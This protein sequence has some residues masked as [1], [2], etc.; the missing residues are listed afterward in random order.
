M[1]LVCVYHFL[2]SAFLSPE[3]HS[4]SFKEVVKE[5]VFCGVPRYKSL[6]YI[7]Q[8][9]YNTEEGH[10][11]KIFSDYLMNSPVRKFAET[12]VKRHVPVYT[13][14]YNYASIHD[15]GVS[16]SVHR[17]VPH[18][19]DV[20][21]VFGEPLVD[22]T[23]AQETSTENDRNMSRLMMHLWSSFVKFGRPTLNSSINNVSIVLE[24]DSGLAFDLQNSSF[25]TLGGLDTPTVQLSRPF[26]NGKT[27]FWNKV[28]PRLI[29]YIDSGVLPS[30]M[31]EDLERDYFICRIVAGVFIT[32]TFVLII[33]LM[34]LICLIRPKRANV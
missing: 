5:L 21:Y 28:V 16:S 34:I 25:L 15:D 7:I 20:K 33:I 4:V 11:G 6:H 17:D 18:G 31:V 24:T 2:F 23:L 30:D 8:H 19:K 27:D 3:A 26:L 10:K 12:L 14:Q 29:H 9:E 32:A 22:T 13:Y 1:N